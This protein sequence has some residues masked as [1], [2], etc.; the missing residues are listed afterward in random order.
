[1]AGL[2]NLQAQ[3]KLLLAAPLWVPLKAFSKNS[4]ARN[5]GEE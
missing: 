2:R 4:L 5:R 3:N 1:M